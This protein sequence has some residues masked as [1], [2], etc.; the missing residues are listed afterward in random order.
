MPNKRPRNATLAEMVASLPPA[1]DPPVEWVRSPAGCEEF[2]DDEGQLWRKVRGP[3]HPRLTRRL[4]TQAD[5][6]IIGEGGGGEFRHVPAADRLATWDRIK[7][8]L[9][10]DRTPGYAPYEFVSADGLTLLYIEENC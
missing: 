3:L 6:L 7:D 1:P 2:V 9:M 4:V 10:V 5:A 8:R